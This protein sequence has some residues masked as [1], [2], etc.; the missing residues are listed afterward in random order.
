ARS[1]EQ[2][3]PGARADLEAY[4]AGVNAFLEMAEQ[5][6][7]L[8]AEY[9]V[10]ELTRVRRWKP[11]DSISILKL[12]GFSL[13]FDLDAAYA[14]IAQAYA[15]ALGPERGWA[16]F[17]DLWRLAPADPASVVPDA[18]GYR[19]SGVRPAAGGGTGREGAASAGSGAPPPGQLVQAW[20]ADLA[21]LPALAGMQGPSGRWFGSNWFLLGPSLS[22][23]GYPILANDPHLSLTVPPIWYQ[24]H[25]VVEPVPGGERTINVWG[26]AFPGVPWVILGHNERIAWGATTNPADQAD[27]Y[28]ERLVQ[29]DGR[30]YTEFEGQLEEVRVLAQQFRVNQVGDGVLDNLAAAP[31]DR[32]PRAVLE[33]PRHGPIVRMDLG[34][35]EALSVQWTGA[36]A[37]PD[38]ETFYLWNRARSLDDFVAGLRYMDFASQN[39]AF[40]D[41]SGNI[42]YFAGAELPLRRDL[43]GGSVDGG[44]AWAPYLVR[45]GTGLRRHDWIP[46]PAN[47][48]LPPGHGLPFEVLPESEMPHVVNPAGGFIVSANNDPIGTTLD[49]DPFND[50][51]ASGGIYYLGPAYSIGFRAGRITQLIR[52][53]ARRAGKLS[54]ADTMAIQSDVVELS[55]LRLLPFLLGAWDRAQATAGAGDALARFRTRELAEAVDYLKGWDGSTPTGL[56]QGW[57]ANDTAPPGEP[58]GLGAPDR[59]EIRSSVAATIANVWVGQ[60]I[61]NTVDAAIARVSPELPRPDGSMAVRV[62]LHHLE[63]FDRT[64]GVGGSGL[65]FF[66][67]PGVELP[68]AVERDILLLTSL[69][70]ALRLLT[71][72]LASAFGAVRSLEDLRWGALHRL[73]LTDLLGRPATA[74]VPPGDGIPVDGG[75]EVVDASSFDPRAATPPAFRFSGGPSVRFIVELRPGAV[76]A[77]ASLPG[78]QQAAGPTN[79]AANLLPTWL[80]NDYYR[81]PFADRDVDA[82]AVSRLQ[83]LPAGQP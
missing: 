51:R 81:V 41:V 53:R 49:G 79:P 72:P 68:A 18:V 21:A 40:A 11:V 3:S 44:P 36:Y 31:A 7:T 35:G 58:P 61:R 82:A 63:N 50:R 71:G 29:R 5:S 24:Q 15:S 19:P 6:G 27:T 65:S 4:A 1:L 25:L 76:E 20:L 13:S 45:D 30:Y 60:L 55:A 66:D 16:A 48:P 52:E 10:L 57:D 28:L 14:N 17:T 69:E 56:D 47:R 37:T 23:S 46:W 73:V 22:T 42:A 74:A 67:L 9:G 59:Q 43:E 64:Q 83:M 62:L 8:P 54:V 70:D 75:F 26:V 12:V 77:Y 80:A 33:V 38:G 39:W 32:V 34:R 2:L 78:S